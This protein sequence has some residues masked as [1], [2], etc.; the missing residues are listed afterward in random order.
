MVALLKD[1]ALGCFHST[2][3]WYP[4]AK[5]MLF[6]VTY[7]AKTALVPSALTPIQLA[8]KRNTFLLARVQ[9]EKHKKTGNF[10]P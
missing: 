10:R 5:I 2:K 9:E 1:P 3:T 4:P 8:F 6:I 7:P